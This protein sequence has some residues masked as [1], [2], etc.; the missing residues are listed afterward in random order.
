M[1]E[2]MDGWGVCEGRGADGVHSSVNPVCIFL[3]T[4]V[5]MFPR[6]HSQY[7]YFH[8]IKDRSHLKSLRRMKNF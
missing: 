7:F 1:V 8:T 2:N 5:V 6:I 3:K 4:T